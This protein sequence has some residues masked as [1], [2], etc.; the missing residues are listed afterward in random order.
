MEEALAAVREEFWGHGYAATS[1]D[2][3][4]EATKLGKGSFYA[5]F[6]DK[7]TVFLRVLEAYATTR[8]ANVKNRLHGSRKAIDAL[9]GLLVP[10]LGPRGCF[11]A[12][13][14]AELSPQD[15]DVV[16][17]ARAMFSELE[18]LFAETIRRAVA[19]GDLPETTRPRELASVLLATANGLEL[20]RR[21]G[22]DAV[23]AERVGRNA[24]RELLGSVRA[25]SKPRRSKPD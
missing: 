12:N 23:T 25:E 3:L 9:Q 2:M 5:A 22:L 15:P 6:G 8:V 10:T 14:T 4:L 18:E 19:E 1:I 16:A 11:L 17:I 13:C 21:T 20:I 24:A 7:R